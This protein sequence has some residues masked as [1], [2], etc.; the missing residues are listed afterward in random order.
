V[1]LVMSLLLAIAPWVSATSNDS[2]VI[3]VAGRST[4]LRAADLAGLPRDTV[5]WPYHGTPHVYAGV[6]LITLLRRAGVPIDSLKGADLTKRVVVEAADHY[7]A[8]FTLAEIAPGLGARMVLLADQEDGHPLTAAVGPW[9]LVVPAD[10]SGAR[11]VR[12]VIA[13]RVRDEP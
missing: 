5:Q 10:G 7:R 6:R 3:E 13:L 8:V 2:V 11:G 12:Q 4:V 1:H 9:R